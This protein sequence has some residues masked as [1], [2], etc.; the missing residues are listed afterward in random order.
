MLLLFWDSGK[1]KSVLQTLRPAVVNVVATESE[2]DPVCY[3]Q[4]LCLVH[5]VNTFV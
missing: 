5:L 2:V 3:L 4:I 1:A